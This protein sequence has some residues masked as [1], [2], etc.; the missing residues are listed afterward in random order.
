MLTRINYLI[1]EATSEE[2]PV[3]S[4]PMAKPGKQ[5]VF[6]FETVA[7]RMVPYLTWWPFEF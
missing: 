6:K 5:Q 4:A 2:S 7:D 3:V 1:L